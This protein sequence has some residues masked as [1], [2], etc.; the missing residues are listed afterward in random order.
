M[1]TRRAS[2]GEFPAAFDRQP[3]DIKVVIETETY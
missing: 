2:L 3:G 1:I